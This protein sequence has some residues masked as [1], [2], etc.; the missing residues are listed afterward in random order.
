MTP[1]IL[2]VEDSRTQAE[3]LRLVLT[4]EGYEV[5]VA[6]DGREG[7][8]KAGA[9]GADLVISDITMPEMDG[10]E[11]CRAMKSSDATKRVPVILRTTRSSPA[12]IIKGLASGAT[13]FIPKAYDDEYLLERVRRI[14]EQLEHRNQEFLEMDVNLTVGGKRIT[15]TADRQQ[16][17]ELL[18]STFDEM[19]RHQEELTRVNRELQEARTE[20]E[21]ANQAKSEFLSRMSHELRTPLNAILGFGQLLEYDAL[22]PAQGES[23][24]HILRGGRHLLDL[25]NEVLDISRIES[26]NLAISL[27]P[28]R[29]DEALVDVLALVAP[30][31]EDRHVKLSHDL[32]GLGQRLVRADRQRLNQALLNLLS[33]AIKYNRRGGVASVFLEEAGTERIRI[34]V[35]DEGSGIPADRLERLF[36]PFDR[37]GAEA[38]EVE[39]TG[40]GLA[41]SKRLVEAMGGALSVE[42]AVGHGSTF[43]IELDEAESPEAVL[44]HSPPGARSLLEVPPLPQSSI[45]YVEDNVPN[46]R[47][48]EQ[49]FAAQPQVNLIS[50]M[51][52]SVALDLARRHHVDLILLD[53]HLPDMAGAEV[54]DRLRADPATRMVP[55]VVLS[56][57]ATDRQIARLIDRGARDYLTKPLDLARFVTVVA[58]ILNEHEEEPR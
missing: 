3:Y 5:E 31:A 24:R 38:S 56:A 37:L 33:N 14:F 53:L 18:L 48:V 43:A 35:R 13:N 2:V 28:V 40:L 4:R 34:L 17:M 12:D 55:V 26:G 16:I 15:V 44:R 22:D 8:A 11:L 47:L 29:L 30:L 41:L 36:T 19:S 45:L 58:K 1:R 42:T 46:I 20:A 39:G 50:A 10:F 27:E 6:L 32:R 9:S 52:G 23:V 54:L 49:L 25:I 7:L 57:D 21:R 51:Q